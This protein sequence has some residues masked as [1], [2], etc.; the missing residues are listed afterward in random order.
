MY[1]QDGSRR[2]WSKHASYSFAQTQHAEDRIAV[3]SFWT[4]IFFKSTAQRHKKDGIP[5]YLGCSS[6][7]RG[8]PLV[9]NYGDISV[10]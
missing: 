10:R 6:R 7:K 1:S 3:A 4:E 2:S 5:G 9:L 8:S